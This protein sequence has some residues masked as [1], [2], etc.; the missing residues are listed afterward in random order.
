MTLSCAS[1]TS[2]E[3][4]SRP[5]VMSQRTSCRPLPIGSMHEIEPYVH[6][7]CVEVMNCVHA[8][9]TIPNHHLQRG[10]H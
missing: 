1:L 5:Q 2:V 9:E 8:K 3:I 7:V 6:S 10:L 4:K